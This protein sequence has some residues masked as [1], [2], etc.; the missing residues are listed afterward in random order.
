MSQYARRRQDGDLSHT[1]ITAVIFAPKIAPKGIKLP[2]KRAAKW[3]I[4][5]YPTKYKN[6]VTVEITRFFAFLLGAPAGI[7][8]AGDKLRLPGSSQ[9]KYSPAK[10]AR[11]LFGA[12]AGISPAGD[13]LR[14]PGRDQK[15]SPR[16][17]AREYFLAL[18]RGFPL[19]GINLDSP[20]ATRKNLPA[21]RRGDFFG[22]PAGISPNG[23]KLRLP[24]SSQKKILPAKR[25]GDFFG[26]PAGIRTPDTLLKRQVLCLLSYWGISV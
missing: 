22:A 12:P 5:R 16:Q 24:G 19:S 8:P 7:S 9:K 6:L 15:K 14:L 17:K 26:A 4:V 3:S 25:R 13:K 23:D 21:K 20:G 11:R 10:K 18:Q 2:P 1:Q